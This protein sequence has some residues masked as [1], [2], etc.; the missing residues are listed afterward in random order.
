MANQCIDCGTKVS[1]RDVKRCRPCSTI[2]RHGRRRQKWSH[3]IMC[4]KEKTTYDQQIRDVCHPCGQKRRATTPEE[5]RL[6]KNTARLIRYQMK[7]AGG[8]KKG[9]KTFE[10]LALHA[11]R[12]KGTS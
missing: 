8:G 10:T 5:A 6:K 7:R 1:R 2:E 3:C 9:G 11:T 12:T 4:G